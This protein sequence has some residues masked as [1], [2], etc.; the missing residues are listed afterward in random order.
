MWMLFCLVLFI[1]T[2]P[3]PAGT[4]REDEVKAGQLSRTRVLRRN[5]SGTLRQQLNQGPKLVIRPN[6]PSP[7][8][9]G[10]ERYSLTNPSF[11]PS[12]ST[13]MQFQ[14]YADTPT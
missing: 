12:T 3:S 9:K 10:R 2:V 13:L 11:S 6:P 8:P 1:C 4:E 14:T 5:T 7:F